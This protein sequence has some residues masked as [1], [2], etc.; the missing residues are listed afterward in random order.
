MEKLYICI[1]KLNVIHMNARDFR[2]VLLFMC[3]RWSKSECNLIFNGDDFDIADWRYST[4]CHIWNKWC[5]AVESHYGSLN[6]MGYFL[7]ECLDNNSLQKL[8]DRALEY[9]S[10]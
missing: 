8:I 10:D 3:N 9:Y 4:G 6:C 7:S 5:E 1:V 2:K